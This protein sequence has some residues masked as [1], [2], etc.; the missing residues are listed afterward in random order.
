[1]GKDFKRNWVKSMAYSH[2]VDLLFIQETR[3]GVSDFTARG[4]GGKKLGNWI[5]SP[6]VGNSGGLIS[7]WDHNCIGEVSNT[8]DRHFIATIGISKTSKQP[9]GFINVYAPQ[10]AAEKQILW[11]KL[12]D[13]ISQD[14]NR[15]WVVVGDFN[16][17]RFKEERKGSHFSSSVARIF[18]DFI[19][20]SELIDLDIG[21][22]K[23]TRMS[24]DGTKLS[25]IDRFL[26]SHNFMSSMPNTSVTAL[27][28]IYSDHCPLLL[29]SNGVDFGPSPFRVFNS[30]LDDAEMAGVVEDSWYK[31]RT[32]LNVFS[33]IELLSRKLRALKDDLKKWRVKVNE[34]KG[35]QV[36]D[37]KKK[38]ATI[39]IL[40]ENLD[41]DEGL[42][43]ERMEFINEIQQIDS[44]K[45]KDIAQKSRC[46][47]DLEGDENSSFFH[48]L[49][50]QN[51][52][53]NRI[54]GLNIDGIWETDP[55]KIKNEAWNFFQ[56]KFKDK[57]PSRPFIRSRKFMKISP[58]DSITLEA[59]F[60]P[61]EIKNAVWSCGNDKAPGPDGFNFR[62]IKRHWNIMGDDIIQAV[63]FFGTHKKINT[64]SNTSFITLVPKTKDPNP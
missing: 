16:E 26:V 5:T 2:K 48:G 12:H 11:A 30:W 31:T 10:S 28:R 17:V 8:V 22:R 18:N 47:W 36:E 40:A 56:T 50:K 25:K 32:G 45:L 61:D 14:P 6:P 63:K 43:R 38:I 42:A 3:M 49:L 21:G 39:D 29:D 60:L 57:F 64:G 9:W 20:N 4:I 34:A 52:H 23:F 55:E 19:Q 27:P 15:E 53:H 33:K 41:I 58:E 46:K 37:L 51:Q 35:N 62:F 7:F 59:D 24:P 1:M 13:I 44:A 54:K